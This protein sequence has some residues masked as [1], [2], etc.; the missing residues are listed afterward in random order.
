MLV[1]GQSGLA[2]NSWV[3][4]RWTS[5]DRTVT[6]KELAGLPREDRL[7]L[8]DAME[9]YRD[10]EGGYRL[11]NYGDELLM[12]TDGGRGQGRCLFFKV[13][14]VR[15]EERLVALLFYKKETAKAPN[16]LVDTAK[17][18]MRKYEAENQ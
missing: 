2:Y 16:R 18:R 8:Y 6:N 10:D 15:D 17:K 11:S 1:T 3:Q 9:S 4:R 14:K 13:L 5:F 7:A 12:L